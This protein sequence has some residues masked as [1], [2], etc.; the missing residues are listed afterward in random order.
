MLIS[1]ALQLGKIIHSEG[2]ILHTHGY[3]VVDYGDDIY[4]GSTS[5]DDRPGDAH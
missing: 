3:E 4:P 5:S 1:E 2:Y